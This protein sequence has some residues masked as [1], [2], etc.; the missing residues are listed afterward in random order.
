MEY[1]W[2][3]IFVAMQEPSHSHFICCH[4]VSTV[5]Y[6]PYFGG[7]FLLC[8]ANAPKTV[9]PQVHG[10]L[11]FTKTEKTDSYQKSELSWKQ[12][13]CEINSD[14]MKCSGV[15]RRGPENQPL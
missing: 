3:P 1:K 11:N 14:L 7:A 10:G 5:K 6:L 2:K 15:V 8:L 9:F 12:R 13:V 4:R